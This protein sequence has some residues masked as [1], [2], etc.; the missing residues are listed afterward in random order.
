VGIRSQSI[1]QG[2]PRAPQSRATKSVVP[3]SG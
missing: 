1:A 2:L 3:R